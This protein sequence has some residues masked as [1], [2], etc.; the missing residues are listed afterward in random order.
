MGEIKTIW[1]P[2]EYPVTVM[3]EERNN[4]ISPFRMAQIVKLAS[5]IADRL[6]C[7]RY[8]YNPTF[9]ECEITLE[10]VNEAISKSKSITGRK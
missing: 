7:N 1:N 9:R 10:L 6:V 8:L 3:D 5:D 2:H 4:E